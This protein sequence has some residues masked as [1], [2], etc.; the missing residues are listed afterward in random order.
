MVFEKN[1]IPWN[2]GL[3]PYSEEQ[4]KLIGS[5]HKGKVMSAESRLKMSN[6]LKGRKLTFGWKEKI[7]KANKGKKRTEKQKL[8]LRKAFKGRKLSEEHKKI[9]SIN[10]TGKGNPFYGKKHSKETKR[11]MRENNWS[12]VD[13][14]SKGRK[15]NQKEAYF[16]WCITN[17]IHRVPDGCI[18][19]HIDRNPLNNNPSNLQLMDKRFHDQLHNEMH[20]QELKMVGG[21]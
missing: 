10:N 5:Y 16:N 20:R 13:G 2:K 3:H 18:I 1:H 14:K 12:Y 11:K 17:H 7:G 6:S 15:R 9:I 4:K 21:N 8:A 19:H